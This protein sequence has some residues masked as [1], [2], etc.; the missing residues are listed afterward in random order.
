MRKRNRFGA[1]RDTGNIGSASAH[2]TYVCIFVAILAHAH[3]HA[4]TYTHI[5]I[6]MY[7]NTQRFFYIYNREGRARDAAGGRSALL[8]TKRT[9]L[10]DYTQRKEI[11]HAVCTFKRNASHPHTRAHAHTH[12][13]TYTY[14][15]NHCDRIINEREREKKESIDGAQRR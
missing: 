12:I 15:E 7:T 9:N 5:H 13:H 8:I 11:L 10:A 3:A 14:E 2:A 1:K 6:N 4:H